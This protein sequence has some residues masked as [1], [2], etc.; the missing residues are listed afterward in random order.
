MGLEVMALKEF[1]YRCER[2]V[3]VLGGTNEREVRREKT[4]CTIP[5]KD[6]NVRVYLDEEIRIVQ[7]HD[8]E[9]FVVTRV[10]NE[11]P[12]LVRNKEGSILRDHGEWA[13]LADHVDKL[14]A[15]LFQKVEGPR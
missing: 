3:D 1:L 4:G 12:V 5:Q 2:I 13:L 15:T 10:E 14:Y 6:A 8:S 7:S 9:A 11:N